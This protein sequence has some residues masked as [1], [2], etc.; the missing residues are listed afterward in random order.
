MAILSADFWNAFPIGTILPFAGDLTHIPD[1][2][3]VCDGDNGTVDLVGRIPIGTKSIGAAGRKDGQATHS[4]NV[5]G[6]TSSTENRPFTP[7]DPHPGGGIQVASPG[8]THDIR[9]SV[10]GEAPNLPLV[11]YLYFIQKVKNVN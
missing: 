8:H 6:Q 4:H 9:P 10:T 2:W 7:Q 1:G 3:E 5:P 11:T